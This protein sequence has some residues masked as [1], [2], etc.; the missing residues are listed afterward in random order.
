[1]LFKDTFPICFL[2]KSKLLVFKKHNFQIV[3]LNNFES[4][5][6]G[7]L[8]TNFIEKLIYNI[9][10]LFRLLRKGVRC[11]ISID[12][13][14]VLVLIGK[15]IYELDL[16]N[17]SVSF[18][19]RTLDNSRPLI[20]SKIDGIKGFDDG[21]YFG[22]YKGNDKRDPIAIYK[23]EEKDK[24][25]KVFE[26][27]TGEIEH[28]HN[29]IADPYKNIVYIFSGDYDDAACIWK[30]EN[31]FKSVVPIMRG[32][33]D[34]RS[35]VGFP[36]INGLIYATDSPFSKNSI[37][38]LSNNNNKWESKVIENINGPCIYGCIWNDEYVFST[39]VEGIGKSSNFLS[40]IFGT[41]RG[42][43]IIENYS[44][45]Y[46]GNLDCSFKE[47]YKVK[48]DFYPFHLFQFG[49]L[50]FPSGRVEGDYLPTYHIGTVK[51]DLHTILL[52][53]NEF[54]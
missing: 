43:G 49:V 50:M 51:N 23:R 24:W 6:V 40:K 36:T 2:S 34:F 4:K 13:N 5:N 37:R 14:I 54:K 44:F 3:D 7:F 17:M 10:L 53:L 27:K 48:K 29:I 41:K 18:G 26:F 32:S 1:M 28:I 35:C 9:P 11:G 8:G 38:L 15:T 52:N 16:S 39:S 30:V 21:I 42:P 46:K 12:D 20:F 47:I 19:Y 22:G 33:Q 45:I 25:V 31:N